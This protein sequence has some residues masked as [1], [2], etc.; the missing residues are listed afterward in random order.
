[1]IEA[2]I[3][4]IG[5]EILIGQIVDTNSAYISKELNK[6]GIK[7]SS[8]ISIGDNI[9]EIIN[10]L[11]DV[12][13]KY[14]IVITTGGLG[15]TKDDITKNALLILSGSD[16]MCLDDEQLG[17]IKDICTKR[18]IELSDL[19]RDQALV[20]KSCSVL[21]NRKG[22]APGMF[23]KISSR[24]SLLFSLPGVPYEMEALMPKVSEL[25]E[26]NI[27]TEQIIH[28]TIVT[29]GVAE[30][31]LATI[32]NDWESS[33][34]PQIKLAYLPNPAIGI[35]LR[36]SVYGGDKSNAIALINRYTN[37]L[38]G[39]LGDIIYGESDDTLESTLFKTLINESK[40]LSV[41]ESCTGG[42]ISSI[43]TSISGS[44]QIFKGGAVVYSN[45][46]KVAILGVNSKIIE[47]YGAVSKEC[48]E[49]MAIKAREVFKTDYAISATGVAGPTG[50]T[51]EKPVGTIWIAVAGE[52][53]VLSKKNVF[54]GDREINTIRFSSEALN[55]LRL[56]L[57]RS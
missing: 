49:E 22:T 56:V 53:F 29:F 17:V 42:R 19:N 44:S 7:V 11:A 5:D 25:I 9:Q 4:T 37:E 46:S 55:F 48:A 10:T 1:M 54:T 38:Y 12:T 40:S 50:G 24:N 23:F 45:E 36:M 35:R 15:P 26:K 31:M 57:K 2:C 27:K 51:A 13:E 14:P 34:P 52:G 32:L 33:L 20:P 18:G 6:M 16:E 3:C 43:L 41:A 47:D 8:I 21:I 39:L 30:S 28:K